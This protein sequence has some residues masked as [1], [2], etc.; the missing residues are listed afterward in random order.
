L[1]LLVFLEY[2]GKFFKDCVCTVA[3]S[4]LS[5]PSPGSSAGTAALVSGRD[6]TPNRS[7]APFPFRDPK[8]CVGTPVC[9]G[10]APGILVNTKD[11]V[12]TAE[13][14]TPPGIPCTATGVLVGVPINCDP[15]EVLA[16]VATGAPT[17]EDGISGEA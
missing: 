13:G 14:E 8:D 10:E 1:A 3:S 6:C 5:L 15:T 9:T 12:A 2:C 11:C 16:G 17:V 4:K 7:T